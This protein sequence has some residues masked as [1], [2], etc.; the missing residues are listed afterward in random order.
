[1]IGD[2]EFDEKPEPK[3]GHAL[4][5][6]LNIRPTEIDKP[7][8]E[9]A[10]LIK[11]DS[12]DD[13]DS[14]IEE[15]VQDIFNKAMH[16]YLNLETVLDSV[17]PKYRARLAEVALQY[18]KTGLDAANSKAKQKETVEKIK[19]RE[20]SLDK[21]GNTTNNIIFKGDR[22]DFLKQMREAMNDEETIDAEVIERDD[23]SG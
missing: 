17:E 13:K 22:N 6:F 15:Q 12:Y 16:G 19:L 10:E 21:G 7:E 3:K 18:L 4:E 1:M 11:I 14:E 5:K 9:N 20:N 2:D 8:Y 23:E